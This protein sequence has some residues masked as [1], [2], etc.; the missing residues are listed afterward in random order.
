MLLIKNDPKYNE[1]WP[2]ALVPYKR[3]YGVDEPARLPPL[4]N[5]G[6]LSPHL[7]EGTPFGLVGTSSLYKRESYPDGVVPPGNVTAGL[8]RRQAIR[9]RASTRWPTTGIA[10]NWVI[11]G[12]DAGRY[13]NSD[14]HAIRILVM[15]P[16]TDRATRP[17][18]GRLFCNHASE[19]LRILGEIPVR[20]FEP[21][22][23]AAARP[24]RQPRHQ[25]PGQDPAD[26][27]F[28]FQTL[29]KNGMVLN[30]AQTWHQLRPG[31]IR[32]DC[33]G[34]HA[35]SQ[36]PTPFEDTAAARPDYPVFDLTQQT[37]L[38]TAKK[39]DQS[40]KKWDART[41]PACAS[42]RASRTSSI[43][44][45]VKPILDRSCVACHTQKSDKPA[46]NLVLDD[47][48]DQAGRWRPGHV[49]RQGARH[50][51]PPGAGPRRR[52]SATSR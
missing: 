51:L 7:P 46:G 40:G 39:H 20:K 43:Y 35:H 5:D 36:K 3:I 42:T 44:R 15:E 26:V 17:K 21:G 10:G 34:C 6:K 11:Q 22:R 19:R 37:P 2:R 47:D 16:T 4:A 41:R 8:R 31:E 18:A 9:S 38:L 13:D 33:G 1:Q 12:A 45:D 27:A 25:L 48:T 52:S 23:Q 50:L 24:R 28:T 49:R 29:D 30:M 32:N 14:I